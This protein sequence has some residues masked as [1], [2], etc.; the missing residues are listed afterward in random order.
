MPVGLADFFLRPRTE[1]AEVAAVFADAIKN[2]LIVPVMKE[3]AGT[4]DFVTEWGE[5]FGQCFFV[6]GHF[7]LLKP[8][9]EKV[10]PGRRGQTQDHQT[11]ARGLANGG[12]AMS[13]TEKNA[14]FSQRVDIRCER[15][16]MPIQ[17][18]DPIIEIIDT[19][20]KNIRFRG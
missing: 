17:A 9:I 3:F 4:H 12:L 18:A 2:S 7:R 11:C 8:R 6:L 15:L 16:W 14:A 13:V 19:N 5:Y 1:T 20:Q 10:K